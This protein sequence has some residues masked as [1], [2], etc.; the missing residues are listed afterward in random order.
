MVEATHKTLK[1]RSNAKTKWIQL[2]PEYTTS[3]RIN[4][5]TLGHVLMPLDLP[6]EASWSSWQA[7]LQKYIPDNNKPRK[8][9]AEVKQKHTTDHTWYGEG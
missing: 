4:G 2:I 5:R 1:E 7:I 9:T 8:H 3:S 6:T